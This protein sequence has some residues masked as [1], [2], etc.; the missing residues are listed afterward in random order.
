MKAQSGS[1]E[2]ELGDNSLAS[3]ATVARFKKTEDMQEQTEEN[4]DRAVLGWRKTFDAMNSAVLVLDREERVI[5]SNRAS[6]LLFK[7]F[8]GSL[9][10]THCWDFIHC[11]GATSIKCPV[12]RARKSLQ[13]ETQELQIGPMWF[14]ITVDPIVDSVGQYVGAVFILNEVSERKRVEAKLRDSEMRYRRLFETAKDGILILDID[15]GQIVDVNPFLIELLGFHRDY[16]IG[17]KLWE[18]GLFKDIAASEAAFLELQKKR[19]IRYDDLPLATCAGHIIDVEFVS[20]VYVVDSSEVIQCNIRDITQHRLLEERCRQADKMEAVGE[21]AGGMA[22]D[23]NNILGTVVGY[24]SLLLASLPKENEAH[25]FAEEI[26]QSAE[27]AAI[28]TRQLLAFGRRQVLIMEDLDINEVVQSALKAVQSDLGGHIEVN[29]VAG[30]RLGNVHADREQLKQV[31]L[32]LCKNARDAMPKGGTLTIETK[33]AMLGR[34]YCDMH[35]WASPGR[36]VLI[37]VSDNGFGLDSKTQTRIFDPYFTGKRLRKGTGLGL[38][39]VYGVVCQHQG[40]VEV[41][42]QAGRGAV[43]SVYLPSPELL[44]P[45][46][47][48][49]VSGRTPSESETI[50]VAEDD[51]MVQRL[52]ERVLRNAGYSVLMASD[53]EEALEVFEKHSAD[54]TLVLLD[55]LM[56]KMDGKKVY[57]ILQPKYPRARFL[58]S[59]GYSKDLL[60]AGFGLLEGI[61]LIEKPYSPKALLR[62]VRQV[63]DAASPRAGCA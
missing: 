32:E 44:H 57:D 24:S 20:N 3:A 25:A 18:I 61:E 62:R 6:C 2:R 39:S 22:H 42:S 53:G 29:I 11:A 37:Q 12:F 8:R 47:A 16:F 52:V 56:P 63:C 31:L 55:V 38:A 21:L 10:G 28:L 48:A 45:A 5:Q 17:K 60:H 14:W 13:R 46:M 50:L 58:F 34:E 27:R 54:I 51:K 49:E 30:D 35:P 33:N 15:T 4:E 9:R 43:F 41:R 40:M 7:D 23:F 19:Y 36:Y 26:A 1:P 59:S